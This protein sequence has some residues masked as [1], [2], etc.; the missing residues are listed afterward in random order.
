MIKHV[1][2]QSDTP[3]A[4]QITALTQILLLFQRVVLKVD[5]GNDTLLKNWSP[6]VLPNDT[7]FTSLIVAGQRVSY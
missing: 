2:E 3:G 4:R 1:G 7:V 5:I 6:G